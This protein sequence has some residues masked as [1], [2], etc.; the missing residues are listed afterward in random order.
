MQTD[1]SLALS[2]HFTLLLK[3]ECSLYVTRSTMNECTDARAILPNFKTELL[4]KKRWYTADRDG[5]LPLT[6]FELASSHFSLV[7]KSQ[8]L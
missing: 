3:S 8:G 2:I 7:G 5:S 1:Q 4:S 6:R